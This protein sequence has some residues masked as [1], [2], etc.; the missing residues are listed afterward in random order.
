MP[1]FPCPLWGRL[2]GRLCSAATDGGCPG[3]RRLWWSCAVC[4]RHCGPTVERFR[5]GA[6]AMCTVWPCAV[7]GTCGRGSCGR[8][9]AGACGLVRA[10]RPGGRCARCHVCCDG[11]SR[12][13]RHLPAPADAVCCACYRQRGLPTAMKGAHA[14]PLLYRYAARIGKAKFVLFAL[15]IN[16]NIHKFSQS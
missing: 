3:C 11:S 15:F 6:F 2:G 9:R 5:G 7:R 12:N 4:S 1:A 10:G 16:L 8:G 13:R 14:K